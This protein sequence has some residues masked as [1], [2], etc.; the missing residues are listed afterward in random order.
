MEP[1]LS[2]WQIIFVFDISCKEN[3]ALAATVN[4]L[5]TE[6]MAASVTVTVYCPDVSPV[7]CGEAAPVDHVYEY[8]GVPRVETTVMVP[9]AAPVHDS[10]VLL[11]A[12]SGA[13]EVLRVTVFTDVHAGDPESLTV[14]V[15]VPGAT[16]TGLNPARPPD[17]E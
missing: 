13:E 10:F 14:T 1:V 6:H 17:Q 15:Y 12:T 8:P 9:F 11:P 3:E 4:T 2:P 5:V 7:S 16:L